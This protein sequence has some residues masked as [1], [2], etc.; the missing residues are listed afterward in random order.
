[1]PRQVVGTGSRR[2]V[3]QGT[4]KVHVRRGDRV[5]V[6]RG[7]Y[8]GQEGTVLKVLVDRNRV[9]VEGVNE[10]TRHVRPTQENPEGGRIK[11]FE[12]IHAS[13]VMLIDPSSGEPS[14]ARKRTAK[15]GSKERIATR[16]GNPIP[17]TTK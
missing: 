5:R 2:N 3:P 8:A 16:S 9:I 10:R 14:R 6:I 12:P 15:D 17:K 13:N 7:N 11:S 1:M 4:G